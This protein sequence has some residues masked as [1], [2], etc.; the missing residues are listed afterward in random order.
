MKIKK[1]TL[2]HKY[3]PFQE[4][5]KNENDE[6]NKH[7]EEEKKELVENLTNS[8]EDFH[9]GNED[10]KSKMQSS[11]TNENDNSNDS[12]DS[13]NSNN[14]N[15]NNNSNNN[16]NNNN[17]NNNNNNNNSNNNNN[18]NSNDNNNNDDN[19]NKN[20]DNSNGG[21]GN[22][23]ENN[24]EDNDYED[25][26]NNDD[27]EDNED[28]DYEDNENDNEDD[29]D[30]YNNNNE[31]KF[32]KN[33]VVKLKKLNQLKQIKQLFYNTI[34]NIAMEK[35]EEVLGGTE[36]LS[37]KQLLK[38]NLNRSIQL[39]QCYIDIK[40]ENIY[41]VLDTSGSME[42][43]SKKL[44]MISDLSIKRKD[45]EIIEAPNF[46]ISFNN[47]N[48]GKAIF[49]EKQKDLSDKTFILVGDFDGG[50]FV[51][52]LQKKNANVV[53]LCPEDRYEDTLEHDWNEH[54]LD[55]ITKTKKV[56][57]FRTIKLRDL[58]TALKKIEKFY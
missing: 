37:I 27:Y 52:D 46:D 20:N 5:K 48:D 8:S 11:N 28:N 6:N 35:S 31:G 38:R 33:K 36:K 58:I 2:K 39:K 49:I 14:N 34:T 40:R 7:I 3:Q 45:I 50:N 19:S 32:N 9:G 43:W 15:N 54:S 1:I 41:L 21:N 12:N 24:D 44:E 10:T 25:N 4:N 13:N 29:E 18:N 55:E 26:E 56:Q 57:F 16:N 22:S 47:Y 51:Y 23:N 53:W 30:D 17:S 42:W